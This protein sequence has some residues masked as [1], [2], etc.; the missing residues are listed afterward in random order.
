MSYCVAVFSVDEAATEST[1][2][3]ITEWFETAHNV[4]VRVSS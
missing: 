1:L 3:S 4:A 2:E